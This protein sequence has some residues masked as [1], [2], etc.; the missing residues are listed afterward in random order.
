MGIK[1]IYKEEIQRKWGYVA[2]GAGLFAYMI[3]PLQSNDMD[4]IVAYFCAIVAVFLGMEGKILERVGRSFLMLVL[5]AS[6]DEVIVIVIERIEETFSYIEHVHY[7]GNLLTSIWGLIVLVILSFYAKKGEKFKFL[8]QKLVIAFVVISGVTI[9]CTI[10]A[11]NLSAEYIGNSAF[12]L[13]VDVVVSLAYICICL[14]CWFLI[15]FREK[16]EEKSKLLRIE[17]ELNESQNKY[18]QL[19]LEKE[20]RKFRHDL[21]NH[22]FCLRELAKREDLCEI[23]KYLDG[24]SSELQKIRE[25][26][27]STGNDLFDA[28]LND[29]LLDISKDIVVTV[30]GKFRHELSLDAIDVCTIFSNLLQNA[31]EELEPIRKSG[32][33]NIE[34]RS[35]QQYTEIEIKN[36]VRRRVKLEKNGLPQTSKEDKKNHGMGLKN[37]KRTV[38]RCHGNLKINSDEQVFSV[39]V[40][41]CNKM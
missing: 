8:T 25:L 30:K 19:M 7:W 1:L 2:G 36:S 21:N 5:L 24:M 12:R 38:E 18:Y 11:L 37:V 4:Y 6:I 32:F 23:K 10:T 31:V 39:L 41:F 14:L 29:K 34:I 28:I 27:Y 33:L 22:L 20:T 13:F 15:Y 9:L 16:N 40:S 35:G 17:R 26:S 3:S